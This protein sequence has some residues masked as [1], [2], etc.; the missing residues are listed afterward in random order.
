MLGLLPVSLL[1]ALQLID[2]SR[3]AQLVV[4]GGA[5]A[6]VG[7]YPVRGVYGFKLLLKFGT[8][9]VLIGVKLN[10][11]TLVGRFYVAGRGRGSNT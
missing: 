6:H 2:M 8:T 1:L 5:A 3:T 7:Q 10:G 4:V 11:Q 9:A